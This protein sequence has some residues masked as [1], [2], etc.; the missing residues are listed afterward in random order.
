MKIQNYLDDLAA[1][2]GGLAALEILYEII[3]VLGGAASE[4]ISG[5]MLPVNEDFLTPIALPY[6]KGGIIQS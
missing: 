1:I 6:G 5:F 4:A 2:V 3:N